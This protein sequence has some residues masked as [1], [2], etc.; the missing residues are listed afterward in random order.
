MEGLRLLPWLQRARRETKDPKMLD[1]TACQ[2]NTTA[3]ERSVMAC[4]FEPPPPSA[5]PWAPPGLSW[6][7]KPDGAQGGPSVCAGYSTTLPEVR[8]VTRAH[9]HWAD[10][11]GTLRDRYGGQDPTEVL[12]DG[13]EL[14]QGSIWELDAWLT[15]PK[16]G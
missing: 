13:L 8:E 6:P 12:L 4:G 11:R 16:E 3:Q 5:Q 7:D 10:G 2:K 9:V 15:R 1:C 14:L